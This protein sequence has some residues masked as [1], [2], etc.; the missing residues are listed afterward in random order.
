MLIVKEWVKEEM[1]DLEKNETLQLFAVIQNPQVK[2]FPSLKGNYIT[3]K[4]YVSFNGNQFKIKGVV[5]GNK[6]VEEFGSYCITN[7]IY[8]TES[9]AVDEAKRLTEQFK[10]EV[11]ATLLADF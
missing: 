7:Q 3:E 11:K 9:E 4:V 6:T 10:K 1:L 2:R 8:S 5:T